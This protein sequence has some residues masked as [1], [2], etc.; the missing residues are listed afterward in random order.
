MGAIKS[1]ERA[2]QEGRRLGRGRDVR[3]RGAARQG[4]RHPQEGEGGREE[5]KGGREGAREGCEE[6]QSQEVDG[7]ADGS[8]R[9]T[10]GRRVG[11]PSFEVLAPSLPPR[12]PRNT[13]LQ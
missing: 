10:T 12:T 5:G 6:V 7:F 8:S 13:N 9:P 4:E 1:L 11:P 2:R 3:G